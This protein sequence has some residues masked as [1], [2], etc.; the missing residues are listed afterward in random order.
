MSYG[1]SSVYQPRASYGATTSSYSEYQPRKLP[2]FS[3]YNPKQG[4][5]GTHV[6]IYLD[7]SI[8]LLG[9]AS[10]IPSLMFATQRVPAAID[11]LDPREHDVCYKYVV[12]AN[13]PDFA[14]TRSTSARVPLRLQLQEQSGR[15]A[16][17]IDVGPWLYL[18]TGSKQFEPRSASEF[19]RKRKS[20]EELHGSVKRGTSPQAQPGSHEFNAYSYGSNASLAYPES[21]HSIDL[22]SMQRKLTPYGKAQS[23]QSLHEDP[24]S[25]AYSKSLMRPPISQTS[26][27]SP[28]YTAACRPSRSPNISYAPSYVT[29]INSSNPANPLLV[30]ASNKPTQPGC[31][32]TSGGS[33][34]DGTFNPYALYPNRASI[35]ICGKLNTMQDDWS[36]DERVAKRRLVLFKGEQNGSTI[37][38]Y[39]RAI[40]PDERP[41]HQATRERRIS[42]IYWEEKDQYFV[43][44]VDTIALLETLVGSRFQ[45]EEKN[46][47]RRNLETHQPLTI[48]KAKPDTEEFFK[49]IMGFPNPKPRNIEKDVK[50]FA[51]PALENAL[52]K[53][54]SKYVSL[55]PHFLTPL[56]LH[57]LTMKPQSASHSS[58]AGALPQPRPRPQNNAYTHIRSH[59]DD[60][61]T[62][63]D[64]SSRSASSTSSVYAQTP[65]SA[66]LSPPNPTQGL[67]YSQPLPMHPSLSH[68]YTV[69][70]IASQNSVDDLAPIGGYGSGQ[71]QVSIPDLSHAYTT[72]SIGRR[73]SSEANPEPLGSINT[74]SYTANP[75]TS[76]RP[77]AHT[78]FAALY[79]PQDNPSDYSLHL[80]T[81]GQ[82]IRGSLDF[83]SYLQS[84]I[85]T[86]VPESPQAA[87]YRR[88]SMARAGA[89]ARGRGYFEDEEDETQEGDGA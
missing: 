13:A 8:E 83:T 79:A 29:S 48:S 85:N 37:N 57:Q 15:D 51:W 11:R 30:R 17:L 27:W 41:S 58:N 69:P 74:S 76:T 31:A 18:P 22:T 87:Q 71:G 40:K 2:E 60:P 77:R 73:R 88:A 24:A 54:I 80:P 23:Q 63:T 9:A 12:T 1:P 35:K 86:I 6:Y 7:S 42:C 68:S 67:T 62:H 21:L 5:S 10:L 75:N 66:T 49:V 61:Y 19:T 52:K 3:S 56:K 36:A 43:T 32:S 45:V 65:L 26:S 89:G 78:S 14:D 55:P 72:S 20:S 28:S 39:F 33:S 82:P 70:T 16:G 34:S 84:E 38:T 47:I 46:R 81:A 25:M 50:V 59:T 44:S 4:H 53:V 64:F